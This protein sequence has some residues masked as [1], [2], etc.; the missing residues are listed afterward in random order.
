MA[1]SE[2]TLDLIHFSCTQP[3]F[4]M[5][6][7][8]QTSIFLLLLLLPLYLWA[9]PAKKQADYEPGVV[10]FKLKEAYSPVE[11]PAKGKSAAPAAAEDV[12][13]RLK[14]LVGARHV[15]VPFAKPKNPK[16]NAAAQRKGRS[17]LDGIYR[18]ELPD[19]LSV[20]EV[21]ALLKMQPEVQYAEPYYLPELLNSVSPNDPNYSSQ[22]HLPII[23]APEAWAIQKG[24]PDI[25][26]GILDT[27]VNFDHPDLQG[28][29][30]YNQA[31][32]QYIDGQI[33]LNGIDD[34]GDGFID[35]YRGWDFADN[36][37]N[38]TA[39]RNWHGTLVT[40]IAA[41]TTNNEV[42]VAGAGFNTSFMPIKVF[43]SKDD[44]FI[45]GYEAIAYAADKG[46]QV[47]N[48]SWGSISRSNFAQDIINYAV[49][50]KDAVIVAAAGNVN[51]EQ[52]WYPASYHNVL[53]VASTE[54][55]PDRI[56][57]KAAQTW[58]RFVDLTA[59]GVSIYATGEGT[60]Y[61]GSTGTSF[62]APQ[63]AA[64]AALVR[65]QF[66]E[67]NALQVME[68]L[69]RTTDDI[70]HIGNNATF[71][72]RLGTGRLNMLKALQP[73]T[74]P[75]IRMNSFA[76]DNGLGAY[77]FHDDE[78][79]LWIDVSNYLDP[80]SGATVKLVAESQYVTMLSDEISLGSLNTLQ[81]ASTKRTPFRF[82][83]SKDLPALAMLS[84]KLEFSSGTYRD[85]Q[86]FELR[87]SG[88]YIDISVNELTLTIA[89]NGNLGYNYDYNLQGLG[90][91]YQN[92][93]LAH[94]MGLL[95]GQHAKATA[96]NMIFYNSP[97]LRNQDF[98]IV[99]RL[100]LYSN[101]GADID[102]RSTFETRVQDSVRLNLQ[103][104]QKILGWNDASSSS[105]VLEYRVINKADTAYENLNMALFSDF[106]LN[107]FF[108]NRAGWDAEN[109]L[110]YTYDDSRG[111][112][113]GVAILTEQEL[114]YHALDLSTRDG[115]TS[116]IGEI[117][118]RKDKFKFISKGVFKEN[119]GTAGSG[120]DVAQVVGGKIDY[121]APKT[122]RKLA[123][124]F[125]T[126]TS[127]EEL[128][129]FT[130]V[131]RQRYEGY[132]SLVP[133]MAR[134]E[135]C[136]GKELAI[137]PKAGSTYRFY[138]D[139]DAS[140]PAGEAETLLL[141]G[142]TEDFNLY[143]AN[144][145]NE[146]PSELQ[147]IEIA[148]YK[149]AV[150]FSMSADKILLNA[151]Q[152]EN[153]AFTSTSEEAVNW[154][155]DFGNGTQSEEPSPVVHFTE[156]GTYTIS[157]RITTAEGC[158]STASQLLTVL[159]R[160]NAP[161]AE[162]QSL[163]AGDKAVI[164]EAD[165]RLFNLY[166]DEALTEL[167]YT[168]SSYE[169]E[170]LYATTLFYLTTGQDET[171]SEAIR[172]ELQVP[173]DFA[174][175]EVAETEIPHTTGVPI[176]FSSS[177]ALAVGWLWD[178]GDGST[179]EE[180]QPSH[181]YTEP[182]SYTIT[183]TAYTA[184]GCSESQEQLI[185]VSLPQGLSN[186]KARKLELYPN[187]SRGKVSIALPSSLQTSASLVVMDAAGRIVSRQAVG[188]AS[189]LQLSLE[190]LPAGVYLIRLQEGSQLWQ[191]RLLRQ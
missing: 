53:S 128:K 105:V 154:L 165:D 75:S 69:R 173:L 37:N 110:G 151:G 35:N 64:A 120:N 136:T 162:D 18:M 133:L 108:M 51:Q 131:A 77:A 96:N 129:A 31:E 97:A 65:A 45:R 153:I 187:P 85:Y 109:Q 43:R 13:E 54:V 102:A 142:F 191:S 11:I 29:L 176:T 81:S 23:K 184:G 106:N 52:E 71:K 17:V 130:Q 171:E 178:F 101:S 190:H 104:Q 83:L 27:G 25:I 168:G 47:I 60:G 41:A 146:W 180:A 100:R 92:A 70:Y 59:P 73:E 5:Y 116:D 21:V 3:L 33:H 93:P 177:R 39:D 137:T 74:G 164:E 82:K 149:P 132:Q 139:V 158:I 117:I 118:W 56:D 122:V 127:L 28:N 10:I 72:D 107:Q 152:N 175:F 2:K 90:F 94:N 57:H 150:S 79:E 98:K 62:A 135:T 124:A 86:Y 103:I 78:V 140:E 58:S 144:M 24:S 34:D 159:R 40:G 115:N 145:D 183:L 156:E 112:Y 55:H 179:S 63:V 4:K 126:A 16:S 49:L 1:A 89:S 44:R 181:T 9:Q 22:R 174:A 8:S 111:L 189:E 119:A 6:K 99:D 48:L 134:Y 121:L 95:I 46:C 138:Y 38:P 84:F 113:A 76:F 141:S 30:H 148:V 87:T 166:A 15:G 147:R 123:F 7:N 182:G 19:G 80:V 169:T 12:S 155:W 26:I 186:A 67:L 50:E 32:L 188:A 114:L 160:E 167:I 125:V 14:N 143:A 36:D 161:L 88:D 157:L 61:A 42:G 66:P 91:R 163:C 68:R 170:A 172:I 185:E 20:E